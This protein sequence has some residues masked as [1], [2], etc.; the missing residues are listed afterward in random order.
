MPVR[1]WRDQLERLAH[2]WV[3]LSR[4]LTPDAGSRGRRSSCPSARRNDTPGDAAPRAADRPPQPRDLLLATDEVAGDRRALELAQVAGV[5]DEERPGHVGGHVGVVEQAE[6]VLEGRDPGDEHRR[7]GA[8][9]LAHELERV[10]QPLAGDPQ[11]VE[12]LDV[13]PAQDRLVGA[14]PLVRGQD[15]RRGGVA[16][17]VRLGRRDRAATARPSCRTNSL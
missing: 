15:P 8:E 13:G 10:A 4:G 17:A 3:R 16:D 11:L 7:L 5:L 9:R 2:G 6:V 14:H 12:R 1:R